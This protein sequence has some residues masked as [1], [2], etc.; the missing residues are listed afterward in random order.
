MQTS[1]DY[2]KYSKEELIMLLK[3]ID[4]PIE[5]PCQVAVLLCEMWSCE[6]CPC[7][8][9]KADKRTKEEH[10]HGYTCQGQLWNW[11]SG[12]ENTVYRVKLKVRDATLDSKHVQSCLAHYEINIARTFKIFDNI[13]YSIDVKADILQD[14]LRDLN[15]VTDY[16]VR[17][18]K[19][20]RL[21]GR[22]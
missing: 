22:K 4:R 1:Q 8:T 16:G 11:I 19:Q 12:K 18:I 15:K 10:D 17:V 21:N 9:H 6:N 2:N 3:E 14:L 20:K 5:E 7:I 13:F